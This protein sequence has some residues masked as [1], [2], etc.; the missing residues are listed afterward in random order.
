MIIRGVEA[1]Q[2]E[3]KGIYWDAVSG[4]L[5]FTWVPTETFDNTDIEVVP[6]SSMLD[7]GEDITQITFDNTTVS[8][9]AVK[10]IVYDF[11]NDYVMPNITSAIHMFDG[12]SNLTT[13]D[14]TPLSGWTSVTNVSTMFSGCSS[15]TTLNLSPLSG[16]TSVTSAS[17]MFNGCSSLESLDL[18]PLSGWTD[19]G[20]VRKLFAYCSSLQSITVDSSAPIFNAPLFNV[21]YFKVNTNNGNEFC[22]IGPTEKITELQQQLSTSY[23]VCGLSQAP[24]SDD[25]SVDPNDPSRSIL[26]L[27]SKNS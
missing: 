27:K 8:I 14:L 25:I 16:W 9:S 18:T 10:R 12:C 4:T 13:L 7:G 21:M 2:D 26:T 20:D 6:I 1:D 11:P 3:Y 15:L 24:T 5:T 22:I 17:S 19:I 23:A